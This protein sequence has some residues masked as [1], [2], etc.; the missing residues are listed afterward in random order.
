L[1]YLFDWGDIALK[2]VPLGCVPLTRRARGLRWWI[3]ILK[4]RK[5]RKGRKGRKSNRSPQQLQP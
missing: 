2:V 3:L 1:P 4:E 5:S